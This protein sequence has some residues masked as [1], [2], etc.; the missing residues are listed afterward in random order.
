MSI[1]AQPAVRSLAQEDPADDD[2]AA[3]AG[4]FNG[5]AIS[6]AFYA[7]AFAVWWVW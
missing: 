5:L 4:L 6:I 2:L 1:D 7:A 3:M